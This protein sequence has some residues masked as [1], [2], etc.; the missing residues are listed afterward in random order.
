[1][2]L[3][4]KIFI[5]VV[6]LVKY[7]KPGVHLLS[8]SKDGSHPQTGAHYRNSNISKSLRQTIIVHDGEQFCYFFHHF[9]LSHSHHIVSLCS[10][11][12]KK[13]QHSYLLCFSY[14]DSHLIAVWLLHHSQFL[15]HEKISP[16]V[17][18]MLISGLSLQR[19]YV[20][21]LWKT[22]TNIAQ[23]PSLL[24]CLHSK[25]VSQIEENKFLLRNPVSCSPA[26]HYIS[27][28]FKR[29]QQI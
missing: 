23:D 17:N 10:F 29:I 3:G 19:D 22:H 15:L 11:P 13:A 5:K 4:W 6:F 2:R 14:S 9:T 25:T 26:N 12:T 24:F 20:K 7:S 21:E 1:M 27:Q 8:T 16:P 18:R 28:L